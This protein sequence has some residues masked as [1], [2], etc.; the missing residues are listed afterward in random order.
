VLQPRGGG[1]PGKK[2][3]GRQEQGP[4]TRTKNS[5][6]RSTQTRKSAR[7]YNRSRKKNTVTAHLRSSPAARRGPR[8]REAISGPEGE[9]EVAGRRAERR[10]WKGGRGGRE[11]PKTKPR[12]GASESRTLIKKNAARKRE[13]E[14][15]GSPERHSLKE[16]TERENKQKRRGVMKQPQ[17]K[18]PRREQHQKPAARGKAVPFPGTLPLETQ[19]KGRVPLRE[20]GA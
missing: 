1:H 8:H 11:N 16:G 4:E 15:G 2:R 20:R 7:S 18:R 3:G 9:R 5:R 19:G 13:D 10:P 17:K 14:G 6:D 12:Q